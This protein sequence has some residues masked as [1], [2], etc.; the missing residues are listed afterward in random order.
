M[1]I[2]DPQ[3]VELDTM[4]D[5][6]TRTVSSRARAQ[7]EI[8]RQVNEYLRNGGSIE[9]LTHADTVCTANSYT[10]NTP[11]TPKSQRIQESFKKRDKKRRSH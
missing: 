9:Q 8:D 11:T 7:A 10:W 4:L 2:R 6:L 1:H 5:A 3:K